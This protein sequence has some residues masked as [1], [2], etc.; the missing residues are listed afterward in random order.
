MGN[1]KQNSNQNN[2]TMKLSL[3]IAGIALSTQAFNFNP[4]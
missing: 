4:K 2:T 3:I 1:H